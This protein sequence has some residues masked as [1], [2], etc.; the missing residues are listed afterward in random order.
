MVAGLLAVVGTGLGALAQDSQPPR[1]QAELQLSFA[2]AV[3]TASPAVVSI[4]TSRYVETRQ[5]LFSNH[6]FFR[7]FFREFH[8]LN[9]RRRIQNSLGSGVLVSTDGLAI[10]A[11][12][13]IAGADEIR[14]ALPDR[15]EFD[16]T[17]LLA[18][19]T[20]DLAVL[21]LSG[22]SDL[23][24]VELRDAEE[25]V[26]GDIVLAIGNPLGVGQTVTSGIVSA[27]AR[28]AGQGR[29]FIQTDA[30]INVGNSGGA[31]IDPWGRLIGINTAILTRTGGSDG[32]GFAVPSNLVTRALAAAA[33]GDRVIPRPWT[34]FEGQEVNQDLA[35]A[36]ALTRPRGILLGL[37]DDRSPFVRAGLRTGDVL[38]S[39]NGRPADSHF[40][41]AYRLAV[42]GPGTT[43][44]ATF[45]RDGVERT[46]EVALV[47]PPED[48][49]RNTYYFNRSSGPFSGAEIANANPA[50]A[51]ELGISSV[52]TAG[53]VVLS[54]SLRSARWLRPGDYILE[55][56]GI[57]LDNVDGM[58]RA[59]GQG[60]TS[61]DIAIQRGDR[62]LRAEFHQ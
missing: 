18:D 17:I 37:I 13:V 29:Y 55:V 52:Q 49:P 41:L 8:G 19:T 10:T 23:P 59:I 21:Q 61:W 5:S 56:N 42:T 6:P 62:R 16:A 50:V 43:V 3:R 60:Y 2:S 34:G 48:P 15:R 4:Y 22:A 46:D 51:E 36:L 33:A 58:R 27:L 31:L 38:L 20:A 24:V 1:Q 45:L 57:E 25:L 32:I 11:E 7:E 28:T 53:V 44:T 54:T 40:E 30:A 26:V 14:V 47:R 35:E 9:T 39:I 12:H